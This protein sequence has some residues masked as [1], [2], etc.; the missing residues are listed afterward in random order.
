M[1]IEISKLIWKV[2]RIWNYVESFFAVF[3]L[4]FDDVCTKPIFSCELVAAWKMIDLLVVIQVIINVGLEALAAPQ[5]CP[6]MGLSLLESVCLKD[7]AQEFCLASYQ[8]E[9]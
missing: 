2:V 8:F 5:H 1:I 4:H 6:I 7:G 9:E 3:L